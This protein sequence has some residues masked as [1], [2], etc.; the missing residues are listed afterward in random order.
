MASIQGLQ[1]DNVQ[2]QGGLRRLEGRGRS[3]QHARGR[4]VS[5]DHQSFR[6]NSRPSSAPPNVIT[7]G[8]RSKSFFPDI[9]DVR[10]TTQKLFFDDKVR[11]DFGNYEA[12]ETL[13]T[14]DASLKPKCDHQTIY[15]DWILSKEVAQDAFIGRCAR[16]FL[17]SKLGLETNIPLCSFTHTVFVN[18]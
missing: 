13:K 7:I 2:L 15:I 16:G 11:L 17:A 10:V 4:R 1:R 6:L 3:G 5:F 18:R 8:T 14:K 9:P 12:A